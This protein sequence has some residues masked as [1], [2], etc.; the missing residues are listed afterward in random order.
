[1]STQEWTPADCSTQHDRTSESNYN[2]HWK[3]KESGIFFSCLDLAPLW[4]W[5]S[6]SNA[7]LCSG[8]QCYALCFL[9]LGWRKYPCS[10]CAWC[11]SFLV[12]EAGNPAYILRLRGLDFRIPASPKSPVTTRSILLGGT[13]L[14]PS[15]WRWVR[16]RCNRSRRRSE[17]RLNTNAP[18]ALL[19]R[20]CSR[21]DRFFPICQRAFAT[22]SCNGEP[23][24]QPFAADLASLFRELT[25]KLKHVGC[26]HCSGFCFLFPSKI[27]FWLTLHK[28][29]G[30]SCKF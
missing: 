9:K 29:P 2:K 3:R 26:K 14:H 25:P 6:A 16:V 18:D 4:N 17:R 8:K 1:M 15:C 21:G 13:T 27:W 30:R 5:A 20:A 12:Q 10:P 19:R 7:F 23:Q 28:N 22:G 11:H 24:Q